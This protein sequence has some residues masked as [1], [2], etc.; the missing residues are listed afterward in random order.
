M[1]D[2]SHYKFTDDWSWYD[3]YAELMGEEQ[4]KEYIRKVFLR[5]DQ[6][7][8]GELFYIEQKVKKENWE[9]FIK[10]AGWYQRDYRAEVHKDD[11]ALSRHCTIIFKYRF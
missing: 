8:V 1:I 2:L 11:I 10:V 5:L 4:L 7:Q 9:L 6:L 3:R